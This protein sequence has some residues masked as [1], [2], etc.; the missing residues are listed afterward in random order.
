[1]K[2]NNPLQKWLSGASLALALACSSAVA[3]SDIQVQPSGI[4]TN[5]D[6]TATDLGNWGTF[7]ITAYSGIT[8]ATCS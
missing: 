4:Q 1:M 5:G 6:S 7:W 2:Q 8:Y 3:A